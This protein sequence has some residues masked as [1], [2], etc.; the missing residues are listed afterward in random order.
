MI[1]IP[2]TVS[3][4]N[5]AWDPTG[6]KLVLTSWGGGY[7]K[8]PAKVLIYD[9]AS[10]GVEVIAAL[11]GIT[12]CSQPGSTWHATSGIIFSSDRWGD[13]GDQIAR[14][15]PETATIERLTFMPLH[16]GYEPSWAPDGT[17]FV[18]ERHMM[19]REENGSI[20]RGIIGS[21]D[22]E[23]LSPGGEDCRQPNCSQHGL[24]WQQYFKEDWWLNVNN[25][26]I[27]RGTDATWHP[28]GR[29]IYSDVNGRLALLDL[30]TIN[31]TPVG[32]YKGYHG[33]PSISPDG[34][35]VACEA[36]DRDPDGSHGTWLEIFDL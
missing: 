34:K 36:L 6:K 33:A 17:H 31:S 22:I 11:A 8:A 16:V 4:Q 7:N 24:V 10:R 19:D 35:Q 2:G 32:P 29:I 14:W 28:D 20:W 1:T 12:N 23:R 21:H 18:F 26:I 9:I 5:P 25:N 30:A 13:D 27:V 15:R 3:A